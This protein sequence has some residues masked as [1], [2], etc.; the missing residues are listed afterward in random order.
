MLQ[1]VIFDRL[2]TAHLK[3]FNMANLFDRPMVLLNLPVLIMD[4]GEIVAFK[5][6]LFWQVN[7]VVATLVFQHRPKQRDLTEVFQKYFQTIVW[8]VEILNLLPPTFYQ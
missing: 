4:F 7:Y 3:V 1:N 8:N 2:F 5:R 6:D